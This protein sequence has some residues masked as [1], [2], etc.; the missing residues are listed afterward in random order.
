LDPSR[1]RTAAQHYLQGRPAYAAGLIRRVVERC[2]LRTI[3][4]VLDLGCGPGQLALAFAPF[5]GQVLGLDPE[6]EMLRVAREQ[7]DRAGR[8]VEFRLGSSADLAPD[9]GRFHLVVIGRAFHWMDR[10]ETLVRL[11][12]IIEPGGALALFGDDHLAVPDNRWCTVFDA[13]IDRYA[14]GDA[15][16]AQWRAPEWR[17]HEAVL[18]GSPF[19]DLERI[20]VVERRQTPLER[21]VDRALSLSSVSP[22]RIGPRADELAREVRE[23]MTGFARDG[24]VTEVVESQALLARR[25]TAGHG[26]VGD[27]PR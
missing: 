25:A 16:R 13:L 19:P 12:R 7:A 3:H 18:L 26:P 23:A 1:F 17:R 14:A 9:L 20:G 10:D 2:A 15:A 11:D 6:P 27:S 22:D 24:Q 8:S 4:R 5:A 21:F